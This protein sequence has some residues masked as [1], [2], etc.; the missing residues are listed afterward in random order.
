MGLDAYQVYKKTQ[1]STASQGKVVVMMFDGAI[2]VS[3]QAKEMINQSKIAEAR[4]KLI[5]AQNIVS[6]LS[7][8]CFKYGYW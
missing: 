5:R 2:K 6:E 3:N 4:R 7:I 1:V 8:S